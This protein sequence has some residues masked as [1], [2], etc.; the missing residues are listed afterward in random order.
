[1]ADIESKAKLYNYAQ[2]SLGNEISEQKNIHDFIN[3][4]LML[5]IGK[6]AS[7]IHFEALE[8]SLI[9]RIRVDGLLVQVFRFESSFYSFISSVIKVVANLDIS[10]KRLPQNSRFSRYINGVNYDFRV[11]TMPTILGESIVIRILNLQNITPRLEELG[12]NEKNLNLIRKGMASKQG[13]ILVTGPTGSGKTTTLYSILKKLNLLNRKIITIEDPVEY[14]MNNIQQIN[15]NNDIGLTYGEALKNVLRQDPD[16]LLIGEIRDRYSL[17]IAIQ[18]ALT[19][20]LVLATLHT[21]DALNSINRLLD[22][23]A[24][25]FLI[26][27]TLKTLISQRLIRKLCPVCKE[28]SVNEKGEPFTS[29]GCEKCNL[30]GYNGREL[31]SEV[32][33]VDDTLASMVSQKSSMEEM[34]KYCM[35]RGYKTLKED[36][37][38]KVESGISTKEELYCT[39]GV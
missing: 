3:G 9:I 11:S 2:N 20:H 22:L 4:V 17:Q 26:S 36:G 31:I 39:I 21:K 23:E 25:P 32:I 13:M 38:K 24:E 35:E 16:I 14:K 37:M 6:N 19:G 1:M 29:K 7:D 8:D 27:A 10:Q 28:K 18:A 15:I 12:F 30:S 5:A 34:S 33:E